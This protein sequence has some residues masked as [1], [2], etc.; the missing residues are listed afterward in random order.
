MGLSDENAV[1]EREHTD[2]VRGDLFVLGK[3]RVL[4]GD[5]T[6]AGDVLRLL[7]G[8]VP[9]LMANAVWRVIRPAWRHRVTQTNG[10]P[11]VAS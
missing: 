4:C 7:D 2:I 5:S 6:S 8:V 9:I 3:H 1:V 10:R 11:S